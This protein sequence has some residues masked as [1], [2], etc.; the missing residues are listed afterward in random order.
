MYP[1]GGK[2]TQTSSVSSPYSTSMQSS[3]LTGFP[4]DCAPTQTH[5][6][7]GCHAKLFGTHRFGDTVYQGGQKEQCNFSV[8]WLDVHFTPF[9][10]AG[11]AHTS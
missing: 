4:V 3:P 9:Q 10:Q 11:A 7:K 8:L 6:S 2:S 5:Q 1:K